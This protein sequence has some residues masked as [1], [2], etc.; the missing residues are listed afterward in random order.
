MTWY[1]NEAQIFAIAIWFIILITIVGYYLIEVDTIFKGFV[2]L[3]L[4]LIIST[5]LYSY[6]AKA[7]AKQ[8]EET[9]SKY[10]YKIEVIKGKNYDTYYT[11]EYRIE[12][13]IVYFN[14]KCANNFSIEMLK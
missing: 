5:G 10:K 2:S 3:M 9:V 8:Y 13:G 14:N 6:M 4:I 1:S 7:D 12:N 11:N